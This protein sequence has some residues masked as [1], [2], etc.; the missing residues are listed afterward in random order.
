MPA[1]ERADGGAAPAQDRHL[2]DVAAMYPRLDTG[3]DAV[4]GSLLSADTRSGEM[5]ITGTGAASG[6]LGHVAA[7]GGN[8]LIVGRPGSG[9]T[10]LLK[11]LVTAAPAAAVRRY[12]FFFDLAVRGR[13][14]TFP[15][16]VTRTL[17]PYLA[18]EAA[19]VFPVFCYF[20]R[21]GSVLCALDGFDEA[22][23]QLTQAGFLGLFTELSQ[24]LSAE[25]AVVM[26]SRVSFLE[27]SPPVRRLLDG[28]SL[29]PEKLL[30]QVHD[31]GVDPLA[32]PRFSVLRLHDEPSRPTPLEAQLARLVHVAEGDAARPGRPGQSFWAAPAG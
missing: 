21:A 11:Q 31:E 1:D 9:K 17:G 25:S 6:L 32:V 2:A 18:V 19:Y 7:A 20:A 29:M 26:T 30:Q 27:D 12:R 10:T 8:L 13:A 3:L 24:V 5:R 23:P 16:F 22:V 15:E 14:E 4:A 28:T